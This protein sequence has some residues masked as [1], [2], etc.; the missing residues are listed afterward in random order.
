MHHWRL[1]MG[2]QCVDEVLYMA[3]RNNFQLNISLICY[4]PAGKCKDWHQYCTNHDLYSGN[5]QYIYYILI[6][7]RR[8]QWTDCRFQMERRKKTSVLHVRA[9]IYYICG[10]INCRLYL[11]QF[12]T[13]GWA[14]VDY[15]TC[16]PGPIANRHRTLAWERNSCP[17]WTL[18]AHSYLCSQLNGKNSTMLLYGFYWVLTSR[19]YSVSGFLSRRYIFDIYNLDPWYI[20]IGC[21]GILFLLFLTYFLVCTTHP[22]F[23]I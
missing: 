6:Q 16:S 8:T 2:L 17:G 12:E 18:L 19:K 14:G 15:R 4:L 5:I 3:L 22:A 9:A 10:L 11:F 21:G 23:Y 1:A 13:K 7:W 20:H